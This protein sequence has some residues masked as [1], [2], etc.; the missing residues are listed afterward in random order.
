MSTAMKCIS[1]NKGYPFILC[2]C[3]CNVG[4]GEIETLIHL[5]CIL[6][7]WFGLLLLLLSNGW[8]WCIYETVITCADTMTYTLCIHHLMLLEESCHM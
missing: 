6:I 5:L 7:V 8:D 1:W 4:L 2:Q 3:A